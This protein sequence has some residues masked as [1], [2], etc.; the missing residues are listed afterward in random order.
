MQALILARYEF[1]NYFAGPIRNSTPWLIGICGGFLAW[2]SFWGLILLYSQEKV[3]SYATGNTT[4]FI[5]I[6]KTLIGALFFL[7]I[8]YSLYFTL[9]KRR[10]RNLEILFST[11]IEAKDLYLGSLLAIFP[12]YILVFLFISVPYFLILL[13]LDVSLLGILITLLSFFLVLFCALS[14]GESLALTID[15]YVKKFLLK[16]PRLRFLL[17]I[18]GFI[19]YLSLFYGRYFFSNVEG[20]SF[21]LQLF[22]ELMSILP[23][24]LALQIFYEIIKSSQGEIVNY[25]NIL[26][27]LI[28]LILLI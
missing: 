3:T 23:S 25:I 28:I 14:I 20:S 6:N 17:G 24:S 27:Y 9:G 12:V 4:I 15:A 16:F 2:T 1:R 18:I 19:T 7:V 11:P 10:G 26:I 8:S 13:V 5:Q 21:S 22:E